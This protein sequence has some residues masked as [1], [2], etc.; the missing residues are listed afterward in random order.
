MLLLPQVP[1]AHSHQIPAASTGTFGPL[2]VLGPARTTG[3]KGLILRQG[4]STEPGNGQPWVFGL[5]SWMCSPCLHL[6]GAVLARDMRAWRVCQAGHPIS[7][8]PEVQG[9]WSSVSVGPAGAQCPV[10]WTVMAWEQDWPLAPH[11]TLSPIPRRSH[12]PA[13]SGCLQ[14]YYQL[15][16]RLRTCLSTVP[17]A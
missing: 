14:L 13:F 16:P 8:D 7:T 17:T 3:R 15:P 2:G 4:V 5:Q 9:K 12:A 6:S 1:Q 11:R 10:C